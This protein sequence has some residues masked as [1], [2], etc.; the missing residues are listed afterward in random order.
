M[1]SKKRDST[2][3]REP[4]GLVDTLALLTLGA[5]VCTVTA[6]LVGLMGAMLT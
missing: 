4:I 2:A 5:A 1:H 3:F 6:M